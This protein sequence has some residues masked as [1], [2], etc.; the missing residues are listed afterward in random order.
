MSK[1]ST[2]KAGETVRISTWT[3]VTRTFVRVESGDT[4]GDLVNSL[5]V[6][7]VDPSSGELV[8]TEVYTH[9]LLFMKKNGHR[10]DVSY[11]YEEQTAEFK[12]ARDAKRLKSGLLSLRRHGDNAVFLVSPSRA[13]FYKN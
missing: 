1:V 4:S 2:G 9:H 7:Y 11:L 13:R 6:H 3:Q 10:Y 5:I 8:E 12:L